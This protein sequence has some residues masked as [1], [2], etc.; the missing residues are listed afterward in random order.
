MLI[1]IINQVAFSITSSHRNDDSVKSQEAI[2][3][4][5]K[6][7]RGSELG[8]GLSIQIE[9]DSLSLVRQSLHSDT[10]KFVGI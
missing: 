5:K 10:R 8:L 3:N 7:N 6:N 9:K 2:V 1:N 4:L